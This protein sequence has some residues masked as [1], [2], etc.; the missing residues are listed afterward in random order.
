MQFHSSKRDTPFSLRS[1]VLHHLYRRITCGASTRTLLSWA[2]G[3]VLVVV[4]LARIFGTSDNA[5][6][7]SINLPLHRG[8]LNA[9][10]VSR[11][12]TNPHPPSKS[13]IDKAS[14]TVHF[15]G[16]GDWGLDTD[17]Y[18]ADGNRGDWQVQ[19][20][21]ALA[22]RMTERVTTTG[23]SFVVNLGDNFYQV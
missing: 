14:G 2:V 16:V 4:F 21:L 17:E 7:H 13:S 18:A 3:S 12:F 23:S 15:L 20:T 22:E 11:P 19:T 10:C 1:R 8:S 5:S 6:H 9:S